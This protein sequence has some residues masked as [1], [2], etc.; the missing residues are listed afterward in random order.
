MA[1]KKKF[2]AFAGV[3][4]PSILTILGVI[5]YMRMGW[6]VGNAGLIGTI[7]IILI[8]HV[9]AVSTGLSVSSIATDKKIGAG[10]IYY[11]LSRSMGIPIGGSIGIALYVGTAFSIALYLIGFAESFNGYFD[12]GTTINDLRLTGTV[13]LIMLTALALISTSAALKAQ[14]FILAA[15][16]ISLVSIFFGNSESAPETVSMFGSGESV[17]LEVVFAIFFPA[18]TGFTAGIAMSGDLENP[19]KSIPVGTLWAIGVGLVVYIT[20][21]VFIAYTIDPELLKTDN[22]ILMKI[23]LF[24]PAVVAGIWGATL[25]SAIGGILGAPRILQ[26]MSLDKVTPKLFGKGKGKNNEPVNALI[27]AFVIA[28]AGIL[29]GELDVIARVVSMF[30]LTAYGFINISFFLESWAN[31]DFQPT[32]KVK[33]WIGLIG[34]V[35]CFAVMFKLDMIAMFGSFAV[36][37]GLYLMLQRKQI[38]LQ[39]ND[40]WQS[41]WSN[42]VNKGLKKL[43]VKDAKNA[44]W[45]PNIILFSGDSKHRTNLLEFGKIVS[46]RTGIVT[47]F[48]LIEGVDAFAK[49]KQFN[50]EEIL[51]KL[52]IYGRKVAVENRYSGIE[53]IASTYGFSGVEP[54]TIMMN[55]SRTTED[56]ERYA[57]MTE[58]LI[59]LDY[60]LLY[61]DLDDR[62]N[63]GD[64]KTID[65]WWRETDSKNAELMLNVVRYIAQS[66]G[67]SKAKI[68]VLFVNQ[69]NGDNEKI[70]SKISKLVENLRV[71]AEIKIINNG[72]EQKSFYEIIELQSSSID[73]ILLGVPNVKIE[74]QAQY[75]LNTDQLFET[76]GT[77]LLVKASKNFNEV[78]LDFSNSEGK[79]KSQVKQIA[80]LHDGAYSG[81]NLY[82]KEYNEHLEKTVSALSKNGLNDISKEYQKLIENAKIQFESSINK[83]D[84]NHSSSKVLNVFKK[85]FSLQIQ[86]TQEFE[87]NKLTRLGEH[88]DE[89]LEMF[90]D[91]RI[92][93][94]RKSSRKIHLGTFEGKAMNRK[95]KWKSVLEQHYRLNILPNTKMILFEFGVQSTMLLNNLGDSVYKELQLFVETSGSDSANRTTYFETFK[96]KCGQVFEALLKDAKHLDMDVIT[97]FNSF[98]RNLSNEL[99]QQIQSENY[100]FNLKTDAKVIQR[101]SHRYLQE[102]VVDFGENWLR[103]QIL[104]LKQLESSLELSKVG[105][106]LMGVNNLVKN[107]ISRITIKPL[108]LEMSLFKEAIVYVKDNLGNDVLSN[109]KNKTLDKLIEDVPQINF[110]EFLKN[111][112]DKMLSISSSSPEQVTVMNADSFNNLQKRQN[113]GVKDVSISLSNIIDFIVRTNY[114]IPLQESLKNLES[115]F[116]EG[117]EELY[118]SSNLVKYILGEKLTEE[119]QR[120]FNESLLGEK[121][122]I[123]EKIDKLHKIESSF[124]Y[125]LAI[126]LK[127]TLSTLNIR[128]I[129]ESIDSYSKVSVKTVERSK[130]GSWYHNQKN[131]LIDKYDAV[132]KFVVQRKRDVDNINFIQKNEAVLSKIER[133]SN[134][135]KQH[136]LNSEVADSLSFYYK[137]LFSGS[138][139]GS[140][141]PEYRS[142][143]IQ[144]ISNGI[145]RIDNGANGALIILGESQ[146]GKSF[147]IESTAN[148]I[149][150]EKVYVSKPAKQKFKKEDVVLAFQSAFNQETTVESILEKV[151]SNTI[152]IIEDIEEWWV[153]AQN[154]HEAIDY[155]TALIKEYGSK[156]YFLLSSNIHS[157]GV[158]RQSTILDTCLISNI[159]VAPARK[160]EFKDLLM[161]RH[162]TANSEVYYNKQLVKNAHKLDGLITEILN[163][164][165][166]N[167]GAGL[168]LWLSQIERSDDGEMKIYRPDNENFPNIKDANWRL[169]LYLLVIHGVLDEARINTMM[170][171]GEPILSSLA[172]MKLASIVSQNSNGD[173]FISDMVKYYIEEWLVKIKLL[174]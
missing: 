124:N 134:F 128:N 38:Q 83:L 164:T 173:Y 156:F 27:L 118:S 52:G 3:F 136:S 8:A 135:F 20:L 123:I 126:K 63:F 145:S 127:S 104:T 95:V 34:F 33:R 35:A 116:K 161:N 17:S 74:E 96:Q 79:E 69:N 107:R 71:D 18:V 109:Y 39:S 19:K 5:M 163:E 91:E 12:L 108:E 16:V 138:H 139:L 73:L 121:E 23:A 15:I 110:G 174:N 82:S 144:N 37:G 130:L 159:L 166:G 64:C 143:E 13:A 154:G 49:N 88:L 149:G 98:E 75:V 9:I 101:K 140:L 48:K 55:W 155:L 70:K 42:V 53:N 29:I 66:S 92:E 62:Y 45:N 11:V 7:L 60:N 147:F 129:I 81:V 44:N 41:V 152:I 111:E 169:T 30:Y 59:Q 133:S 148:T 114:L 1:S 76:V 57:Q 43:G 162:K 85:Y 125:E 94:I 61:L 68:R 80:E 158:L 89:S 86:E 99:I 84:K 65:I 160:M 58:R 56:P 4:T 120:E 168:K 106:T 119:N 100:R 22:N 36:V 103:N 112:E 165:N 87:K 93:Y 78:D 14:F 40:V 72:V 115:I 21:A 167:T 141:N 113:E 97:A 137:K 151:E 32:F 157:Y 153:K 77:T 24:A 2:G 142:R 46:G 122:R 90:L 51:E 150:K 102:E 47:D 131:K 67:W 105:L 28:E 25:S 54:N 171:N 132:Y 6:V 170:S 172:E 50:E 117:T 26:A 146:S 31:P 10:G